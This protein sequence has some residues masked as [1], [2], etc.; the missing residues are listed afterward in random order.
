MFAY[1]DDILVFS[2]T[3]E[4]H[5]AQLLE[6]FWQLDANKLVIHPGKSMFGASEV[7][8]CSHLVS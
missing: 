4:E 8:F 1:I 7:E 2:T 5:E 6:V 3:P